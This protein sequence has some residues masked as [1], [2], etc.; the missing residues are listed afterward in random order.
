[1][2][3]G[4]QAGTGCLDSALAGDSEFHLVSRFFECW[5]R[6][7]DHLGFDVVCGLD[8]DQTLRQ[9]T[10][11]MA[12]FGLISEAQRFRR[13]EIVQ[14]PAAVRADAKRLQLRPDGI[15]EALGAEVWDYCIP[16][17]QL[18]VWQQVQ[19][20]PYADRLVDWASG[21]AGMQAA[22]LRQAAGLWER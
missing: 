19:A 18:Q 15:G 10:A 2:A 21:L 12:F 16:Q 22:V 13:A 7:C 14:L 11:R 20:D 4:W 3:I 17:S 5:S 8:V 6:W 1:V 9:L